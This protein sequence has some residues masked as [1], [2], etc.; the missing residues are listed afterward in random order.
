M[1]DVCEL[2]LFMRTSFY[3]N[4]QMVYSVTDRL[5]DVHYSK[6]RCTLFTRK[7]N[8]KTLAKETDEDVRVRKKGVCPQKGF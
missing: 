7:R 8:K 6:E 4:S 3:E 1:G 2:S 5:T